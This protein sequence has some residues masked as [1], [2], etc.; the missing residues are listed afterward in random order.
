MLDV[1]TAGR[2]NALI[3]DR[4]LIVEGDCLEAMRS[5]EPGSIDAI[6][7]DPP[8]PDCNID[9]GWRGAWW[10]SKVV[11]EMERLVMPRGKIIIQIGSR[12]DPRTMLL[13]FRLPHIHTSWAHYAIPRYRGNIL[14]SGDVIYQFGYGYLPRGSRVLTQEHQSVD[15]RRSK[16]ASK[17][18]PCPRNEG[19]LVSILRTQVGPGRVILDPFAGSGTTLIA[20]LSLGYQCIGVE[21]DHDYYMRMVKRLRRRYAQRSLPGFD[22]AKSPD[23]GPVAEVEVM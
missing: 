14:D 10:W 2:N 6:V 22:R 17:W 3:G 23:Y 15:S 11:D 9:T 19:H 8:W 12:V 7:T 13:P 5:M 18:H 21:R 16:H 4:V 1:M 20:A